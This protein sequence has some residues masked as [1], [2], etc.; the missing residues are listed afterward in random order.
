M[1]ERGRIFQFYGP[2]DEQMAEDFRVYL[3]CAR[4]QPGTDR[5]FN[6]VFGG[7]PRGSTVLRNGAGEGHG[8]SWF[9]ERGI[10]LVLAEPHDGLRGVLQRRFGSDP[11]VT[12]IA[13]KFQDVQ[14]AGIDGEEVRHLLYHL[15]DHQWGPNVLKAARRLSHKPH[16]R[17]LVTLKCPFTGDQAMLKHFGAEKFDLLGKVLPHLRRHPEF[18][19]TATE[20]NCTIHPQSEADAVSIARFMMCDRGQHGFPGD[21]DY[22]TWERYVVAHLWNRPAGEPWTHN[23]EHLIVQRN[24]YRDLPTE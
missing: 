15:P 5:V 16:S 21:I 20:T 3:R 17:L 22:D 13:D 1:R 8:V 19:W 10:K 24:P 11:D 7:L 12:I 6:D 14:L 23:H 4:Q 18:Q 9:R 2:E